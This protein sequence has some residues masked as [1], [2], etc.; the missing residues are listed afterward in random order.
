MGFLLGAFG[1]LMAGKR[2]RQLQARM[3]SVQSQ[4]RRAT[5]DVQ[6]MEK[7][8]NQ[9]EKN[10]KNSNQVYFSNTIMG[11]NNGLNDR[12][13][14]ERLKAE[15]IDIPLTSSGDIDYTKLDNNQMMQVSSLRQMMTQ[16]MQTQQQMLQSELAQR[17]AMTENELEA[18]KEMYL[19]PLKDVEEDLQLEK[20]SLESQI[21]LAQQDY[22]ACKEMEKAGAKSLTPQYTGQG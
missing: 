18:M 6:N 9:M 11:L 12:S 4:M 3:M 21:Q 17:N 16:T 14:F 15:N 5:R 19:Q 22:E 8:F 13:I 10:I 7:Y 20:D 2:V 1:K